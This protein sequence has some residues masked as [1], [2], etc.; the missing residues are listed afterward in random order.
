MFRLRR[1][2]FLCESYFN[3]NQMKNTIFHIVILAVLVTTMQCGYGQ[4]PYI[5][6][7]GYNITI[8]GSSNVHDWTETVNKVSGDAT[9]SWNTDGSFNISQLSIKMECSSIK[10]EHGSI[11][12]N[13][14]FDALKGNN[15]PYITFK[16]TALKSFVKSGTGYQVKIQGDLTIAGKTNSVEVS[17]MAYVKENGKLMFEGSKSLKM[18]SY[19]IDPPTAMMGAMKVSDDVTIKFRV[20]YNMK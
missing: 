20:Y 12:D 5:L 15:Y 11:M 6:Y 16:M 14:T 7:S 8:N 9:V 4:T 1:L 13:K 17:G 3:P 2:K 18:S 19:G 10:S